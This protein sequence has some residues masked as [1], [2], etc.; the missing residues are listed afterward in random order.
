MKLSLG[1]LFFLFAVLSFWLPLSADANRYFFY[2]ATLDETTIYLMGSMHMGLPQDP[3]YPK[4]IYEALDKSTAFLLEGEVR[5]EKIRNSHVQEANLPHNETIQAHLTQN[6][7]DSFTKLLQK[8]GI[9]QKTVERFQPWFIEFVVGYRL[10]FNEGYVLEYGTEHRLLRYL[11]RHRKKNPPH[12]FT[13]EAQ[14]EV[15]RAMNTLKLEAQLERFRSFLVYANKTGESNVAE[16]ATHWRNGDDKKVLEIFHYNHKANTTISNPFAKILLYDRNHRM[17]E[18]LRL[19]AR[20]PGTYF[21]VT[22]AMHL[23]GPESIVEILQ[24]LGFKVERQ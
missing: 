3:E 22:G 20:Y 2:K 5:S 10:A 6:E 9:S 12:I 8:L 21:F 18:R 24:Q 23:I 13:I 1:R 11:A 17:A 16:M 14:D 15:L 19:I 7:F 4:K